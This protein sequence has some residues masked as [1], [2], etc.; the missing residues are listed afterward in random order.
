MGASRALVTGQVRTLS[1]PYLHH[2]PSELIPSHPALTARHPLSP[3]LICADLK[4]FTLV[5]P[6]RHPLGGGSNLSPLV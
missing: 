4:P 3:A 6:P 5:L 2:L 1:S